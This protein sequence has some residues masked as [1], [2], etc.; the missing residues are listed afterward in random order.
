MAD[1]KF[2]FI[3]VGSK[4]IL[5]K[6]WRK[7]YIN[8]IITFD[9]S[10]PTGVDTKTEYSGKRFHY[11]KAVSNKEGKQKFNVC[12]KSRVSSLYKPDLNVIKNTYYGNK[13]ENFEIIDII[14][15]DCIRIDTILNNLKI[16]F[17][18]LKVDAQGADLDVLL[19]CGKYLNEFKAIQI[20][21]NLVPIYKNAPTSEEINKFLTNNEFELF[22]TFSVTKEKGTVWNDQI[23]FNKNIDKESELV[24]MGIYK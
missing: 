23:Y 17:D 12:R 15:I 3:D 10:D 9:P 1:I 6:R 7:E 5:D 16:N 20:E 13:L 2:N 22:K 11:S 19:S 8:H 14:N 18:F 24:L 4:G 21:C